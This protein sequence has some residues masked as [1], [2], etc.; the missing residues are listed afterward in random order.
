MVPF[1]GSW[2]GDADFGLLFWAGVFGVGAGF[3]YLHAGSGGGGGGSVV[4]FPAWRF[5]YRSRPDTGRRWLDGGD[6]FGGVGSAFR[7]SAH[8]HRGGWGGLDAGE[9]EDRRAGAAWP[10]PAPKKRRVR[11]RLQATRS[12]R[13][14]FHLKPLREG[15]FFGLCSVLAPSCSGD[16][17]VDGLVKAV[18]LPVSIGIPRFLHVFCFYRVLCVGWLQ[19]LYPSYRLRT[20]LY[21]YVFMDVFLTI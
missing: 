9:E 15:G 14:R 10:F 8:P 19:F 1:V 17:R 6:G 7:R 11:P 12:I 3:V 2:A 5:L 20:R 13:Y 18:A 4:G 16:Q 21:S